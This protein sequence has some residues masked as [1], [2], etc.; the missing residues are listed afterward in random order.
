MENLKAT[1]S[2]IKG[3]VTNE[4]ESRQENQERLRTMLQEAARNLSNKN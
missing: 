3:Y 1:V 2:E 4:K